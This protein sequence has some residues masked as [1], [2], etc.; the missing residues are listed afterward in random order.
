MKTTKKLF[1]LVLVVGSLAVSCKKDDPNAGFSDE[2]KSIVPSEVIATIRKNGMKI[3]EGKTP[4]QIEGIYLFSENVLSGSTIEDDDIGEVYADYRYQFY[5]QDATTLAVKTS[6]RGYRKNGTL[7]SEG[8][9][10][11]SFIS[12]KDNFFSI[13]S[14][15][16]VTS[17]NGATS[18]ILTIYSGE[19][20]PTG[21]KN[22]QYAF[23]MKDKN[24]PND[25]LIDV[26]ATRV[27]KDGDGLSETQA[28]LRI[29]AEQ[30]R[31]NA[32]GQILQKDNASR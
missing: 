19:Y 17:A 31:P 24:D 4:P 20:T 8:I 30:M 26:G 1:L 5:E 7:L 22:F 18:T 13:F 28:N 11:G 6:F 14:E 21:I 25:D 3:Y 32:Q 15:E 2:I 27:F 16:N 9:G 10:K 23:Y 29:S 12:G